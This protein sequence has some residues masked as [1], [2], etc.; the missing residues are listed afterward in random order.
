MINDLTSSIIGSAIKIHK[1]LGPGLL[2]SAYKECLAYELNKK[3]FF[4]EKEKPV[5]LIFE[6]VKLECGYR[7]D[8]LINNELIIEIK[9]VDGLADIHLAQV[10]TY[11]KL[12]NKKYGLIINF[13]VVLLKDGIK[14]LINKYYKE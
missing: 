14:R 8:L 9:S 11:M 6:E 4:V 1:E 3:G 10:L 2:E 7:L 13:N 5:P 12:M